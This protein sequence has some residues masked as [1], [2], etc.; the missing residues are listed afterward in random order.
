MKR[1]IIKGLITLALIW[2]LVWLYGL[3]PD[4]QGWVVFSAMAGMGMSLGGGGARSE[5]GQPHA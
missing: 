4:H 1:T 3:L 2:P 5:G